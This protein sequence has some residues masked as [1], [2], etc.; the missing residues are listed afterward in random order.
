MMICHARLRLTTS[1]L[2]RRN[3]VLL[4]F[5]ATFIFLFD[6]W[7]NSTPSLQD[8]LRE[9]GRLIILCLIFIRGRPASTRPGKGMFIEGVKLR[10]VAV[11]PNVL[12]DALLVMNS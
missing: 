2:G 4:L 3:L 7:P 8:H 5:L 12:Q 1:L 9:N 6:R 10:K 11:S